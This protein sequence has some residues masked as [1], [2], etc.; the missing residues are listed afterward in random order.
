MMLVL[1]R[2]VSGRS[3]KSTPLRYI[4]SL[5]QL[6]LLYESL[7]FSQIDSRWSTIQRAHIKTCHWFLG[8]DAY[9]KWKNP[10]ESIE[11]DQNPS[12]LLW[13]KG[14]S[15]VG[16]STLMKYILGQFLD[17]QASSVVISFF[18]NARGVQLEKST[19][20]MYRSLIYQLLAHVNYGSD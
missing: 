4:I 15:G 17:E 12:N 18:F 16:K 13:I 3:V 1:I 6:E 9:K 14:K 2:P 10:T 11:L 20:E 5:A 8:L 7:K 19:L